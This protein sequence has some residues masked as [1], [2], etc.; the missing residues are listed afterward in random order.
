MP[1][2][3]DSRRS[4]RS[5][6][7]EKDWLQ[8][9][10]VVEAGPWA[11]I[12][13]VEA[14]TAAVAAALQRHLRFAGEPL[15]DVCVALSDDASVRDLNRRYRGKDSATN[16]LSFPAPAPPDRGADG[17]RQLGDVIL[18]CETLLRE[19]RRDGISPEH[20]FQHLLLHG[21]LHLLG[22]DHQSDDEA[23]VMETLEVEILATLGIDDPYRE[24]E[25]RLAAQA[26]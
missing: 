21:L 18:A 6:A 9:E 15:S 12:K 14:L 1:D 19:A 3:G 22:F 2:P 16:V 24:D 26:P 5:A 8:L 10:I 11:E 17:A 20:H 7:Q 23:S 25:P 4:S 13:D